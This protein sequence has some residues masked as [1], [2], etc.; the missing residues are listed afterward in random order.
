MDFILTYVVK[1]NLKPVHRF[2]SLEINH[3]DSHI[4]FDKN[5]QIGDAFF[6]N[7]NSALSL[8]RPNS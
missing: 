5:F 7:I 3:I 2:L 6:L 8:L 1:S 4:S